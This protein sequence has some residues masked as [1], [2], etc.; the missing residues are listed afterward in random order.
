MRPSRFDEPH[1]EM[2]MTFTK[3]AALVCILLVA[4]GCGD[5]GTTPSA[6]TCQAISTDY[7]TALAKAS[8][9]TLGLANRC[10]KSVIAS[11]TCRCHAFVSGST[12][13]LTAISAHFD[14]GGCVSQ[15]TGSCAT[16]TGATCEVDAT[17]ST[18]GRCVGAF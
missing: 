12:D 18:G 5:V 14:A 3:R 17:S 15:C 4:A 8:E 10:T 7:A 2:T 1:R 13:E 6:E 11:F 9:C 16:V